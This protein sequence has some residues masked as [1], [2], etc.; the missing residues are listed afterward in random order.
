MF[1]KLWTLVKAFFKKI[2]D[3]LTDSNGDGDV[4]RV[5]GLIVLT[6]GLY[7]WLWLNKTASEAI[8]VMLLGGIMLATGKVTDPRPVNAPGA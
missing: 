3:L 4:V 8:A 1:K 5:A 2:Q 7:G 6:A